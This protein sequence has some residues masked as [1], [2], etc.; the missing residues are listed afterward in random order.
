MHF[1]FYGT[2][3]VDVF[4]FKTKTVS[5]AKDLAGDPVPPPFT[6][7][8]FGCSIVDTDHS[9]VITGATGEELEAVVRFD[10]DTM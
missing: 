10:I 8:E 4:D 1:T 2:D 7:W 5:N 9:V 6:G 3:K